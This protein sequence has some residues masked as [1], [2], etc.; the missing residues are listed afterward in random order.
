MKALR[1][2][3]ALTLVLALGACSGLS[4]HTPERFKGLKVKEDPPL[5]LLRQDIKEGTSHV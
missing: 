5:C 4:L 2:V 1:L 3:L